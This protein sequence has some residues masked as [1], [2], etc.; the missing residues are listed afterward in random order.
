V[1]L[2]DRI[3]FYEAELEERLRAMLKEGGRWRE[4][5]AGRARAYRENPRRISLQAR[6][7]DHR[8]AGKPHS[9][10][11]EMSCCKTHARPGSD[12]IDFRLRQSILGRRQAYGTPWLG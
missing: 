10:L 2:S 11:E 3:V 4:S 1:L 6:P 9:T 12:N 5:M 7:G 8:R